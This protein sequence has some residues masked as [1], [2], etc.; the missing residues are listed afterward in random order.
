MRFYNPLTNKVLTFQ[1]E[2]TWLVPLQE[3]LHHEE[4]TAFDGPLQK[5]WDSV[6]LTSF[7]KC[8]R[9]YYWSVMKGYRLSPMPST[10]SFGIHFHTC[11]EVW[12]KLLASGMSKDQ[13]LIHCTKLAG[14]LGEDI[15][16]NR[17]ERTK[18][19]LVR[20]VVWYLDQFK[21]D[22]AVTTTRPDGTP[23]VEYSFTIPIMKINNIQMFLSGHIDRIVEFMGEIF[24]CDYKTTKSALNE[25]FFGNFKPSTQISNYLLA[26]K[27]M[28]G[29]ISAIPR[30]P[31]GL[32]IDGIQLG[33]NFNRFNRSVIPFSTLE[34]NRHIEDL[35]GWL[36]LA[37][38]C[39]EAEHWPGNPASCSN[40][41][42]C[43]F[44]SI[45]SETPAKWERMLE[46]NFVRSTWDPRQAR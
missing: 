5:F 10:L 29:T 16:S 27:I 14:L 6:S 39:A 37:A 2:S 45:C 28:A 21:N 23:A 42:G 44:K 31:K 26:A 12:H 3:E 4:N 11:L 7:Q 38:L 9:Y 30:Q 36:K 34:I 13:A 17:T 46:S 43:V 22:N 24:V 20:A 19:T 8:P 40:Y 33:V 25:Q 32:I 35:E 41:G 18:E 15:I 1:D